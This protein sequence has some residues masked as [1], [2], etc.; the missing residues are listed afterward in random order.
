MVPGDPGDGGD[1]A[2]GDPNSPSEGQDGPD[3]GAAPEIPTPPGTPGG[4]G[5]DP[6]D[7]VQVNP[8]SGLPLPIETPPPREDGGPFVLPGNLA[9]LLIALVVIAVVG[10][11]APGE[12]QRMRIE[13]ASR[14]SM[15]ARLALAKG[16]FS[17]ALVA[18]D[19]AIEQAHAAYTR[20]ISIGGPAQWRLL[21][22]GFYISLWRGRAAALMG[23]GRRRSA[24]ATSRLADE[25]EAAV[26]GRR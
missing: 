26:D 9:L 12:I 7:G 25:L 18:F 21:P 3:Q 20:R 22:D 24:A 23:M 8:G 5:T 4:G 10:S 11:Y 1:T 16:D 17:E 13:A 15:D 14:D 19:R 6:G 2:P